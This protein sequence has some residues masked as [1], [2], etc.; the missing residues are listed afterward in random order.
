MMEHAHDIHN[1]YIYTDRY[2][3]SLGMIGTSSVYVQDLVTGKYPPECN[4]NY[5]KVWDGAWGTEFS[6]KAICLNTFSTFGEVL[7]PLK[8]LWLMK[9]LWKTCWEQLQSTLLL[10]WKANSYLLVQEGFIH[11]MSTSYEFTP[12][13]AVLDTPLFHPRWNPRVGYSWIISPWVIWIVEL[14]H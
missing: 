12:Y 11:W 5:D 3:C 4:P 10:P 14:Y 1:I 7:K 9:D 13:I 2:I 8:D 6:D